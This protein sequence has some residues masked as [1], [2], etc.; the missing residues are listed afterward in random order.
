MSLGNFASGPYTATYDASGAAVGTPGQSANPAARDIGLVE[1][2][3]RVTR[4]MEA[5]DI[6]G[7]N[8]YGHTVID[9]IYQGGNCFLLMTVKEW[10]DQLR[11]ILW[12]FASS[13]GQVG[14]V[15]RLLTDLAGSLTLTPMAG[16][17]A[18]THDG[19]VLNFGKAILSPG[20]NVEIEYGP[21]PRDVALVF[22]CF[23]F[24]V[25]DPVTEETSVVWFE[26]TPLSV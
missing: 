9:A 12:P 2:V 13:M 8:L 17:P 25:T 10:T 24:E 6:N 16:T 14:Q 22:R 20:H 4:T 1:N 11:D 3:H 21:V 15:G 19:Q 5:S 26:E 23:P 7:T 18:A